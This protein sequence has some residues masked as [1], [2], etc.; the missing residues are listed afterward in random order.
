M[1]SAGEA[2]EHLAKDASENGVTKVCVEIADWAKEGHTPELAAL[3]R[4]LEAAAT[5]AQADAYEKVVDLVEDQLA[6]TQSDAAIDAILAL[7]DEPRTKSVVVPRTTHARQ[8][9]FASRLGY[10]Q[11]KQAFVAALE[12]HAGKHRDL[13]ACWM[14]ELVLRRVSLAK[15]PVAQTLAEELANTGHR[16]GGLPLELRPLE[17]EAPSYMPLYGDRGLT[18]VLEAL[19]GGPMSART[20]P[21][22]AEG[23]DVQITEKEPNP[24]LVSAVKPWQHGKRGKVEMKAF[25]LSVPLSGNLL[26]SW[27]LRSLPLESTKGVAREGLE[28]KRVPPESVFGPLFAAAANGGAYSSG[29]GGAYGRREAWTTLGALVGAPDGSGVGVIEQAAQRTV[30]LAFGAEG[31]WFYDVA[32]DLGVLALHEDQRNVVVLAAT[33]AE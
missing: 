29:I 9:A 1:K 12:R 22:P 26:G 3:A 5:S 17:R 20:M 28:C 2:L 25:E 23:K 32:W 30:F 7:S 15:E 24:L 31:P 33:D 13:F 10:A 8:C 6:L 18:G 11:T 21:P 16:L 27:L 14:H 4:G 19:A